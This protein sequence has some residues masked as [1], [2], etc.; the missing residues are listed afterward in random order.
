MLPLL[1]RSDLRQKRGVD[2]GI[3]VDVGEP[4]DIQK[5]LL[6]QVVG[7]GDYLRGGFID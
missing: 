4:A 3:V 2:A 7:A 1:Q 6:G 5:R